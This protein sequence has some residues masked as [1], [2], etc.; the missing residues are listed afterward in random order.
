MLQYITNQHSPVSIPEQVQQVLQGGCKWIQLRMKDTPE[1]EI[2][3]MARMLQPICKEHE[4]IFVIDD[5]VQ[6]AKELQ[7]DGVHLG[8][9]D[10]PVKEARDLLGEE[11]IIGATANTID[12]M[13]NY[14]PI[15]VDYIGLGPYRFTTT[16][17]N[18]SPV[19]GID[20]YA[21]IMTQYREKFVDMPVVAIGG[22]T[23]DDVDPIMLT[24][25]NGIAISGEI[26]MSSDIALT[27]EQ[28]LN[29]L[30]IYRKEK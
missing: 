7:L 3:E 14:L 15:H 13:L 17:K 29:R 11:F 16:K 10:M 23:I 8:K 20:G 18:L 12:D 27:T 24:G 9:N 4:A 26:A 1:S 28:F 30:N 19:L 6:I 5:H 25:V 22:I 21:N 2:V